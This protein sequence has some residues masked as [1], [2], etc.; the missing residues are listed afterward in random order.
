MY[1]VEKIKEDLK[2]MLS[3][4][5][6]N[7]SLNVASVAKELASIYNVNEEK[8]YLAGLTHDIAKE[9]NEEENKYYI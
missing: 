6:Y 1:E 9:F 8:A 4:K 5:R 7:H 2:K 3:E